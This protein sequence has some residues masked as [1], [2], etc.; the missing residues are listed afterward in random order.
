MSNG[1][2]QVG[3]HGRAAERLQGTRAL[4]PGGWSAG[5]VIE[6][7]AEGCIAAVAAGTVA[8]DG[9]LLPGMPNAHSHAF[10]RALAGRSEWAGPGADSFW[11]WREGM[12]ALARR[13]DPAAIEV[14]AT[15]LYTE[16]LEAGYTTVCEFHYL[17]HAADGRRHGDIAA[18][19]RALLRAAAASGI[20]LT[21]LPVLYQQGGFGGQPPSAGQRGFVLELPEYL[22]LLEALRA[23]QG[24][25]V[26]I[27]IGL[28]SLRA[29]SPA[30]IEA[31]LE[32]RAAHDPGCPVHIHVAEQPRE[33]AEC[34]AWSGSRPV[35]W[36]LER[37]LPDRHWCL[38]HA[39]HMD[40]QETRALAASGAVVA[41]CPSTEANLGDGIFP[42]ADF[43][44]AGGRIAIGSDSQV[45]VSP[46]E[47]LRWLEYG[48]RLVQGR[49]NVAASAAE[50]HCGARLFR[51][52]LAGGAAA[53]GQPVG[54][55]ATGHAADAIELDGAHPALAGAQDDELLD[56]LVFA[57]SRPLLRRAFVAGRELVHDGHH[58]LAASAGVEFAALMQE[59]SRAS[60]HGQ[61]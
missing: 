43:L 55:L 48:Q 41:L 52:A 12:Y 15:W 5:T 54:A 9:I 26:R 24:P 57:G 17:H 60:S 28:H 37:G 4:L 8:G 32:W 38:V 59:A 1:R 16:M 30:A 33:V 45:S 35:Q 11:S 10:Q 18:T 6:A 42:L 23:E 39:T 44:D 3:R 2:E 46:L 25:A 22:E 36:L 40:A 53:C 27:G 20:R 29:V 49:R 19:S 47:E 50:P 14:I 34:L 13:L 21:L 7:D 58:R 61:S 31:V 56:R 51:A